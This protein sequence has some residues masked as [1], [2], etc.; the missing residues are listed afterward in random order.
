MVIFPN[1]ANTF[2]EIKTIFNWLLHLQKWR[3][4]YN[5]QNRRCCGLMIKP[6]ITTGG[7]N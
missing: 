5:S 4:P 7:K 1:P 2:L 6:T 3:A